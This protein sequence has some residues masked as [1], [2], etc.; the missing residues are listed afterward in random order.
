M[1]DFAQLLEAQIPR[2]RRY[3]RALTRDIVRGDDLVQNRL[4]GALAKQHLWQHGTDLRAWLLTI[5]HNQHINEVRRSVRE[6]NKIEL[7]EAPQLT[8]PSS[9]IP[10]VLLRHLE[11][12]IGKLQPEQRQVLLLV[13]LEGMAYEQVAAILQVPVGTVR[14]RL[15]RARNQLRRL[16]ERA[17]SCHSVP[18]LIIKIVAASPDA[19]NRFPVK[20]A[21]AGKQS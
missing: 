5:L 6:G 16:M 2:L 19:W 13:G 4:T 8:V 14:S 10:T 12:A 17:K 9:A 21:S 11:V 7:D 3:A 15:S 18:A 1:N 20:K